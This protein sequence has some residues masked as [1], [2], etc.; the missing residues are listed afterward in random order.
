MTVRLLLVA[1]LVL[2]SCGLAAQY[3]D[4]WLGGT[5]QPAA[6]SINTGSADNQALS[7][8]LLRPLSSFSDTLTRVDVQNTAS[9][10]RPVPPTSRR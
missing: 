6:G 4:T 7:F 9:A 8:G 1:L 3:D 5:T 2:A 10:L